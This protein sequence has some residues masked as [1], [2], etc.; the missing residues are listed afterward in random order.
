MDSGDRLRGVETGGREGGGCA[1][2]VVGTTESAGIDVGF[3]F[4]RVAGASSEL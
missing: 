4:A 2:G 1:G 3:F